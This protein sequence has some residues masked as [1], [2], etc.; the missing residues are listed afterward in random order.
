MCVVF[1]L[2]H[3]AKRSHNS[4][5]RQDKTSIIHSWNPGRLYGTGIAHS[6]DGE[7]LAVWSYERNSVHETVLYV[8]DALSMILVYSV[9]LAQVG[10][11]GV[12]SVKRMVYTL[13]AQ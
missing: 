6:I 7:G 12:K 5:S 2:W 1:C 13:S 3:R 8:S 4:F 10:T 11:T 9:V